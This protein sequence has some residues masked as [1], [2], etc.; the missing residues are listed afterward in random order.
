M[1]KGRGGR[2]VG[3]GMCVTVSTSNSVPKQ[4]L[5]HV[6]TWGCCLAFPPLWYLEVIAGYPPRN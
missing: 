5:P 3:S 6:M 4:L 1:F 2:T